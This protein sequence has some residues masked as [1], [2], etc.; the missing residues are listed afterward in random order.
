M[1]FIEPERRLIIARL[2]FSQLPEPQP[3]DFCYKYYK[4]MVDEWYQSRRWSTA[5]RIFEHLYDEL[6]EASRFE[7]A[8]KELA[9]QVFFQ[10]HVMPYE[11]Q[12][13]EENGDI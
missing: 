5:H 11:L 9:W 3:G 12:K 13:R 10:L 4:P 2:G 8:A 1:P 7:K 6:E